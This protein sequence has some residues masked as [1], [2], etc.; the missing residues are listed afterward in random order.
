M[1][2]RSLSALFLLGLSAWL[3]AAEATIEPRVTERLKRLESQLSSV[4]TLKADFVQEKQMAI[5]ENVLV[6]KGRITL[7]QPDKVAWRVQSPIRYGMVIDGSALRQWSEDTQAVQQFSLAGN[8]VFA[9][10]VKQIQSWFSGNYL[11]LTHEF[12][13][14]I[15]ADAPLAVQFTPRKSSPAREVV[16]RIVMRF[17]PDERFLKSLEVEETGGDKMNLVF[18]ETALNPTLTKEE[19]DPRH[20]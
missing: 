9:A 1:N 7:Q 11:A 5:L 10:A 20:E 16:R 4:Q 2:V 12:E 8:P 15:L 18:R 6:L 19:W 13:V 3:Q 17:G 14:A